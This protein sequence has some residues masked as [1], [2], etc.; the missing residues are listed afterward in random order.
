MSFRV[1][2]QS[3]KPDVANPE[4]ELFGGAGITREA[5]QAWAEPGVE[6]HDA[7]D[8]NITSSVSVTGTVDVNA[9]GTYL[10]NYSVADAAGNTATATRTVT[11]FDTTAPAL[12]LLGDANMTHAKNTAWVD[13]GATAS[14]SLDGNLTSSI[15]IIGT[16]DV[17]NTGVYTLTYS[18]SDGASNETNATRAVNVIALGPWNFTNAGTAGR[19]GPTQTQVD[20]A[21]AG[22]LLEG[23]VTI[24]NQGIQEW[25]V[26]KS[27]TYRIESRGD[28]GGSVLSEWTGGKGALM[29]GDFNLTKG[30]VLK[31]L[32]G[33]KG[34]DA[35][36]DQYASGGNG[37]G[38]GTFVVRATNST[39]LVTAGRGGGAGGKQGGSHNA[40]RHGGG[41]M[42]S[43]NGSNG[44]NFSSPGSFGSAGF[45]GQGGGGERA[46]VGAGWLSNGGNNTNASNPNTHSAHG[47][48]RFLEGGLGG[49]IG[50]QIWSGWGGNIGGF[51]GDGAGALTAGGGGGYSGGGAGGDYPRTTPG[52]GGGS[53]NDGT[54]QA[55][56]KVQIP[57]TVK[58]QLFGCKLTKV[59]FIFKEFSLNLWI[60]T[61]D[62]VPRVKM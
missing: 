48:V 36:F 53:Y 9:T 20:V 4:L 41:G 13:P 52:G 2:F 54:N 34:S 60:F 58:S 11:V 42:T 46:A 56:V 39:P 27:G 47:G 43:V 29:A 61:T 55:N 12:T 16:V 28:Q 25:V 8:G 10:L 6:A 30:E 15:T 26:P 37:G 31:V 33:Q 44:G 51:G 3:V 62:A 7:R 18:V 50:S 19:T 32:V 17:N 21:Y 5:G 59:N 40:S 24:N 57:V 22:D 38:G 35:K 23:K 49:D 1:G 45:N 14:D